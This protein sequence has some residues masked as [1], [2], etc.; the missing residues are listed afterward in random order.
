M[1]LHQSLGGGTNEVKS[2]NLD[3][4]EPV[5]W[6]QITSLFVV[7][8]KKSATFHLLSNLTIFVVIHCLFLNMHC[9]KNKIVMAVTMIPTTWEFVCLEKEKESA[10]AAGGAGVEGEN[11]KQ[12]PH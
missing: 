10:Q 5:N 12:I 2:T 8:K 1:N 4:P 11:L 7:K 6:Q 3:S 9:H